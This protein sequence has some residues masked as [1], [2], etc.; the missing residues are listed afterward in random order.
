VIENS[1]KKEIISVNDDEKILFS[2]DDVIYSTD[3]ILKPLE[4]IGKS[5]PSSKCLK[6]SVEVSK[7]GK[8]KENQKT[9][10]SF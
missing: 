3:E 9:I 5:K 10:D 2:S 7:K 4:H 1:E 8:N 6:S